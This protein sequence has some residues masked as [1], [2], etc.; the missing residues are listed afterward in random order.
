MRKL[1]VLMFRYNPFFLNYLKILI[2]FAHVL[3]NGVTGVKSIK[4]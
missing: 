4:F 3:A 2:K 1:R